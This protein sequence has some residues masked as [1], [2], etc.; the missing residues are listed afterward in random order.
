MTNDATRAAGAE[1]ERFAASAGRWLGYASASAGLLMLV[2]GLLSGFSQN[3]GLIFWGVAL[4]LV[5]W[6]VLIR[7]S[8]A[9]HVNGVLLRNMVRDTLLPW[10]AVERCKVLQSLQVVASG[11]TF[12]GLA[13]SRSARSVLREQ[14][15][16]PRPT[17]SFLG[18]GKGFEETPDQDPGRQ[19]FANQE[20]TGGTYS[21]Y[22]E[23]RITA[24]AEKAGDGDA[25]PVVSW[26]PVPIVALVAAA[27]LIALSFA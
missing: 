19:R 12:H 4:P 25:A 8:V 2:G 9:A 20:Q 10:S 16:A 13:I 21:Q 23:S 7:P 17:T 24:L 26:V 5:S 14:R 18:F 3:R 1:T 15:R 27:A 22:V 11:R 6:V